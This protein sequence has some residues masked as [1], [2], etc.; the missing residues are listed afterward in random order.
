MIRAQ[1]LNQS[2]ESK[3]TFERRPSQRFASRR[4]RLDRTRPN[5]N[6]NNSGNNKNNAT[7][8]NTV[9]NAKD[10]PAANKGKE[11]NNH[12]TTK[13][14]DI[15]IQPI[16]K[17]NV[18]TSGGGTLRHQLSHGKP[19]KPPTVPPNASFGL[20]QPTPS[21]GQQKSNQAIVSIN[22][23]TIHHIPDKK[24]EG[25]SARSDVLSKPLDNDCRERSKS[26]HI[27]APRQK[28]TKTN[29]HT[30]INYK[31]PDAQPPPPPLPP[32]K[33]D[34]EEQLKIPRA[35]EELEPSAR[36]VGPR[37]THNSQHSESSN[38]GQNIPIPRTYLQGEK[39]NSSSMPPPP[40]PPHIAP[41][42]ISNQVLNQIGKQPQQHHSQ[43]GLIKPICVTEL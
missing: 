40:P 16:T 39:I 4:S 18:T 25:E 22:N 43:S 30:Y 26:E 21:A 27:V 34:N 6:F 7:N 32:P 15:P 11:Q 24:L 20:T 8:G 29:H 12:V 35:D 10:V 13:S 23:N 38:S 17:P 36:R 37:N 41:R 33:I 9:S 19:V 5:I 1:Q 3:S 31:A 2:T 14:N 42:S 28:S